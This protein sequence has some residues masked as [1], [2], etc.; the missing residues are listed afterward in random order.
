[1]AKQAVVETTIRRTRPAGFLPIKTN[2]FDRIFI[3]VVIFIA[4]G[5]L[6]LRFVE[7]LGFPVWIAG[8]I[9]VVL[10]IVIVRKG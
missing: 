2:A 7:P 3:S 8:I 4:L 1:M 6:W 10:G 5:L 9:G